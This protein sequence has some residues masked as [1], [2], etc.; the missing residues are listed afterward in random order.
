MRGGGKVNISLKI[1]SLKAGGGWI[2]VL[3]H[4]FYDCYTSTKGYKGGGEGRFF[5]QKS[6]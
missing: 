2:L 3:H 4:R 6:I 5:T 1:D